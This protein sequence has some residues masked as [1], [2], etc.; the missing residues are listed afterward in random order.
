[1]TI[2]ETVQDTLW[3]QSK[4]RAGISYMINKM[5]ISNKIRGI[6]QIQCVN[7]PTQ[8]AKRK[9]AQRARGSPSSPSESFDACSQLAS[10]FTNL[11]RVQE[12]TSAGLRSFNYGESCMSS[13][14]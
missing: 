6:G 4:S 8:I 11:P 10:S 5:Y 12:S 14:S 1:M 9:Q 3:P 2:S 13:V 7:K